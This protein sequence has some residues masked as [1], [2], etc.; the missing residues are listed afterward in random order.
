MALLFAAL[1][2]GA[3]TLSVDAPSP[4]VGFGIAN[5]DDLIAPGGAIILP[6]SGPP[7]P[8]S[9]IELNAVSYGHAAGLIV[10]GGAF[11]VTY[12]SPGAPGTAVDGESS[13]FGGLPGLL[14]EGADI[15]FTGFGGFNGQGFDGD[16]LVA[17]AA[18]PGAPAP[19]LGL[20]EGPGGDNIDALDLRG[21][22]P[23]GAGSPVFFSVDVPTAA[24]PIYAGLGAEDVLLAPAAPGFAGA[25]PAPY[26]FGGAMG[27][28]PGDDIDALA[29]FDDGDGLFGAADTVLFSLSG[30]SVSLGGLAVVGGGT[31]AD[32]FSYTLG[33]GLGL[34]AP[35]AALGLAPGADVDAFDVD[36]I[37][38]PSRMV[39][40]ALGVLALS[41][42]RRRQ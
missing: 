15:F 21:G 12:G 6:G 13:G 42:R 24:L 33:G 5:E 30:A 18:T 37:P 35:E 14:D 8:G 36:V 16:G 28:L 40:L 10:V 3:I 25:P 17:F 31:A 19:G 11:S 29:V 32:I 22:P 9:G 41:L 27:L 20:I 2:A 1:P 34:F 38:E 4:L 23:G 39:L 26:V 7:G